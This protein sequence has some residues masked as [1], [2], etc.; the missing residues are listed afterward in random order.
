ME[1]IE[2]LKMKAQTESYKDVIKA[3]IAD[4]INDEIA[5]MAVYYVLAE[6]LKGFG[7]DEAYEEIREHAKVEGTE[8]YVELLE[9]ASNHGLLEGITPSLSPDVMSYCNLTDNKAIIKAIQ[10]LE[11]TARQKYLALAKY[12]KENEDMESKAFFLEKAKDEASHFDDLSYIGG[13]KRPL[14]ESLLRDIIKGI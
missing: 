14:G 11:T 5:S 2:S 10:D 9:Y 1:Y 13:N 12:A 7:T 6:R 3:G 8:H 4:N